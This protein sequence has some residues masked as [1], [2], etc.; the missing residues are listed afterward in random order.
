[1][2]VNSFMDYTEAEKQQM[3]GYKGGRT[4]SASPA[5]A[6]DS[7][8][9]ELPGEFFVEPPQTKLMKLIR[10]Q[11][12]C[13]SCWAQAAIST[14]EG[15]VEAT[16]GVMEALAW[17]HGNGSHVP[18]TP[19]LSTQTVVSCVKNPKQCG[20]TGGCGGATAELA[21]D[22]IL[23][24]GGLPFAADFPYQSGSGSS[25][26][27]PTELFQQARIG[28][29]GYT[30]L[31]SNKLR[32][33]KEALVVSGGPI[34][35]SVDATNWFMYGGGVFSDLGNGEGGKGDFIVNHAVTL[36]GYSD[37]SDSS[38]GYWKVKNSWGRFWGENGYIRI[39]MKLDEERHCGWDRRTHVGIACRDDPDEAWVCG[40]CGIL[41]DSVYPTGIHMVGK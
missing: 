18:G 36:M 17:L 3:L 38:S 33:L 12:S 7:R 40:T 25:P 23:E 1:M 15:Q 24:Q 22:M 4:R 6:L 13:G 16:Q 35:I 9:V 27:C 28:I 39:E 32:P 2:G 8:D 30:V 5:V 19:T 37:A 14:L 29:T 10:D 31:P 26:V 21:Y 20:G 11:G 41:Y 34:A